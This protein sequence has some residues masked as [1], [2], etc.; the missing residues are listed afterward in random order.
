VSTVRTVGAAEFV[1]HT[2]SLRTLAR[3]AQTCQGCELFQDATQTVF[4]QGPARASLL[5]VGEQPGDVEDVEGEPF[6]GP[7]GRLLDK[8]MAEAGV[9]RQDVF[10]TNAVKHF[11]WKPTATGKRRIHESPA[12]RHIAACQ[13]WLEAEL[14]VVRPRIVMAM[15]A[16]AA[17]ALLGSGFRLSQHRGEFQEWPPPKGPFATSRLAVAGVLATIHPSAVLRADAASREGLYAGLVDDLAHAAGAAADP[18]H[19]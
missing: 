7:A 4:G 14:G 11:R 13:P 18:S 10:L 2:S 8:A 15:G 17:G 19:L 6:V 12:T 9:D 16:V 3:A 1:P 5:L